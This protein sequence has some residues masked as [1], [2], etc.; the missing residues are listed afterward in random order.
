MFGAKIMHVNV[1]CVSSLCIFVGSLGLGL[2][3]EHKMASSM[4][5]HIPISDTV[6]LHCAVSCTTVERVL[7]LV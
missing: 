7:L 1:Q 6:V 4:I 2:Y 5:K 3:Q